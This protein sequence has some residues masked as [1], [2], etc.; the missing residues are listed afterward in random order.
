[1]GN[2]TIPTALRWIIL[3][4]NLTKNQDDDQAEEHQIEEQIEY[5]PENN[6]P[7]HREHQNIDT[8]TS[9]YVLKRSKSIKNFI[10]HIDEEKQVSFEFT[11]AQFLFETGV[12][13]SFIENPYYQD[14]GRLA[15]HVIIDQCGS[16][17]I[18]RNI[19][20]LEIT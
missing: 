13:F 1:M 8:S 9:S 3:E 17:T 15:A 14:V 20:R 18:K 6:K 2:N 19:A 7:H 11:L 5:H 12:P 10:D 16:I 4:R